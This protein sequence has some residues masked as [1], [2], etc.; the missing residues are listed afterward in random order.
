MLVCIAV[1]VYDY[2]RTVT[3][4]F[5]FFI[6]GG[7]FSGDIL[8]LVFINGVVIGINL[9]VDMLFIEEACFYFWEILKSIFLEG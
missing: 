6:I 4:T 5:I 2:G 1:V 7:Y 8:G 3:N 9:V